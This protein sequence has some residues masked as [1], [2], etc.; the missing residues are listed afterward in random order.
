MIDD[1]IGRED[2]EIPR[3]KFDHRSKSRHRRSH[4][5]RRKAELGDRRIDDTFI[6]KLFPKSAG[7]LISA[8]VLSNFFAHDEDIL[9]S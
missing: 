3:H 5:N 9:V 8:I 1:L 2:R 6:A 4:A 7:H